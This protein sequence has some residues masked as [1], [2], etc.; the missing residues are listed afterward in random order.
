MNA[1]RLA[2]FANA[3]RE[4]GYASGDAL[5]R[6]FARKLLP[7]R[8]LLRLGPRTVRIDLESLVSFLREQAVEREGVQRGA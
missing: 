7:S 6:A 5:R 1:P 3:G 8:F 2:T 4:L